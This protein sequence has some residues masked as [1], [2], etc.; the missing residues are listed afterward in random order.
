VP[1]RIASDLLMRMGL[2]LV[3]NVSS[4]WKF[5]DYVVFQVGGSFQ[6]YS[7]VLNAWTPPWRIWR[8]ALRPP[9]LVYLKQ[10]YSCAGCLRSSEI[11]EGRRCGNFRE[12]CCLMDSVPESSRQARSGF[13]SPPSRCG[14]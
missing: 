13:S 2:P 5:S 4:G 1:Q 8:V 11:M 14:S 12:R 9:S 6:P 10:I 7:I 3:R